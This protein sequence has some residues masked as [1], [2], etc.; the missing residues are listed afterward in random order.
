MSV[1]PNSNKV[2]KDQLM[3]VS[4]LIRGTTSF[5]KCL[6]NVTSILSTDV[7]ATCDKVVEDRL[8]WWLQQQ[9]SKIVS[10]KSFQLKKFKLS[11]NTMDVVTNCD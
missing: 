1:A 10:P 11:Q 7:L 6:I 5:Q 8:E 3:V 9:V 2:R 4:K